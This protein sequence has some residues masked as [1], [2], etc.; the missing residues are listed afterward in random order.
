V[1]HLEV[2]PETAARRE[3]EMDRT[4]IRSRIEAARRLTFPGARVVRVDA[5]RPLGAVIRSVKKEIWNL[6]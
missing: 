1:I 5:E 3:P 6:L 2:S 4:V